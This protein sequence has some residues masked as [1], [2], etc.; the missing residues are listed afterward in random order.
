[1]ARQYYEFP[2]I[3]IEF[4]ICDINRPYIIPNEYIQSETQIYKHKSIKVMLTKSIYNIKYINIYVSKISQLYK[5]KF[6]E[7]IKR[8]LT[9][10]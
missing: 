10:I 7:Y 4:Q 3:R 1:M 8:N 2:Y 9:N 5:T 6:P